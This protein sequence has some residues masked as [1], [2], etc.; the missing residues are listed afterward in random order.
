MADDKN[1]KEKKGK[2]PSLGSLKKVTGGSG[3][4][5]VKFEEAWAFL[6][7]VTWVVLYFLKLHRG[8]GYE[9]VRM[10][11]LDVCRLYVRCVLQRR[12]DNRGSGTS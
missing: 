11:Y 8:N 10:W 2:E 3:L 4:K 5:K 1:K 7:G 12:T 6:L 9:L